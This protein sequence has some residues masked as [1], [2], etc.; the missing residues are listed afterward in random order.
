MLSSTGEK[1]KSWAA[2][3]DNTLLFWS[4]YEDEQH[5]SALK[6]HQVIVTPMNISEAKERL[7]FLNIQMQ[8][9]HLKKQLGDYEK[10]K[11]RANVAL[12]V[13]IGLLL[14]QVLKWII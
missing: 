4:C 2:K 8:F 10:T 14:L 3:R 6:R 1:E 11:I 13:A 5:N 12:G 7:E 9:T